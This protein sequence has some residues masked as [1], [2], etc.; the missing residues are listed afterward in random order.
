MFRSVLN[1]SF[2]FLECFFGFLFAYLI[3]VLILQS[4]KVGQLNKEGELAMYVRSNGVH[5]DVCFPTESHLF[6]WG[7]MIS[8]HDFPENNSF[9]YISIGWGDKG[10]FLDT[11]TWA[12]LKASTAINAVFFPSPTAMHIAYSD[13]PIESEDCVEVKISKKQYSQMIKFIQSSFALH[14]SKIMLIKGKGYSKRDNFYEAKG[15]YHLF[16]TCN[17]WTNSVLR[18][19]G[20][21]TSLYAFFPD[22]IMEGLKR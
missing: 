9:D 7:E 5:T 6:N 16:K 2:R 18:K 13:K 10:F 12:E 1:N 3:L 22:G 21:H 17:S 14:Q 8:K 20:I 4:I 19:G 11:P 15:S